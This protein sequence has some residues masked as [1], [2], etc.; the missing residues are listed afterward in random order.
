MFER[1]TTAARGVVIDAQHQARR[2]NHHYVGT[3]HLLLALLRPDSGVPYELLTHAGLDTTAVEAS[4]ERL[5]A[6]GTQPETSNIALG[7]DDAEALRAIGIDLEA[8]RAKIEETFGPGALQTPAPAPQRGLFR[9]R[10][11][12]GRLGGP[13]P[14]R[15]LP[16]TARAR[17]TLALSLRE[18]IALTHKSIGTEHVL[19][20]LLREGDGLASAVIQEA[21]IDPVDLRRRTVASLKTAA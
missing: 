1:F 2:L 20:G 14:G 5:G 8:I 12:A 3:E 21:G 6:A 4:I 15:H 9:R 7:E 18:A 17:K 10:R 19:L 16:F 11:R 13:L